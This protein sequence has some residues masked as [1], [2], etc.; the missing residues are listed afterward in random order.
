MRGKP[1][2]DK[3]IPLP[4]NCF[5]SRQHNRHTRVILRILRIDNF[6]VN[7]YN[8]N[9]CNRSNGLGSFRGLIPAAGSCYD[10]CDVCC[11]PHSH[12]FVLIV[13]VLAYNHQ[14]LCILRRTLM[15]KWKVTCPI[16]PRQFE[17]E[18][19]WRPLGIFGQSRIIIV[20]CWTTPSVTPHH[21]WRRE[22]GRAPG[23][24]NSSPPLPAYPT[25]AHG[26]LL[27]LP[28]HVDVVTYI[29]L[30]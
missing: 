21:Q 4:N 30:Q 5:M 27:N 23:Q 3:P 19:E 16:Q 8:L 15:W 1:W 26:T 7:R 14:A 20:F 9:I 2:M 29:K 12:T 28:S 24:H 10:V 6:C 17:I 25:P 22:P 13:V 18:F 11:Q